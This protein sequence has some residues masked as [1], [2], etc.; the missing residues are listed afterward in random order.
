MGVVCQNHN[1]KI[2]CDLY[3]ALPPVVAGW[4]NPSQLSLAQV[5]FSNN[6]SG[7]E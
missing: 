2:L 1:C 6:E 4:Q 5:S 3:M 7:F